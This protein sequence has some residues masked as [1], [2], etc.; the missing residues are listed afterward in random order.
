MK[1]RFEIVVCGVLPSDWEAVT[2]GLEVT[3]RPDGNTQLTGELPD[4]AAL[5]GLLINLRDWGLTLI[6]VNP[7]QIGESEKHATQPRRRM[8]TI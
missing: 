6:S 5:Y 4:Q 1:P 3:S 7:I 8:H 2:D